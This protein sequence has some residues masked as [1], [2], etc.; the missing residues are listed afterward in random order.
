MS[1]RLYARP[2]P[3]FADPEQNP[4]AQLFDWVLQDASG[5]TQAHGEASTREHIEQT[6]AQNALEKVILIGLIPGDETT[7]CVADIPARQSRFIQQALPFAVEEQVAQDIETVHLALGRHTPD[8]YQVAAIDN[9]QMARWQQLFS[10][11][12]HVR[13]DA[14]YPDA[15]LLPATEGGWSLCLDGESVMLLSQRGEWLRMQ[16]DNL[17]L[18]AMTMATPSEDEVVAEIPV[19]VFGTETDLD[20]WQG[21]ISEFSG[22]S[23]RLQVQTKP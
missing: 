2:L 7:F 3:P 13:L 17:P 15:A 22:S 11:W 5:D 1:Y 9:L 12:Q 6:L 18:F 19:Q 4:D 20:S 21:A 16:A 14:I 10:G 8:G 23:G